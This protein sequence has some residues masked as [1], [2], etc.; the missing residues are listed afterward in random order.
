M[1]L[2]VSSSWF[3]AGHPKTEILNKNPPFLHLNLMLDWIGIE[4]L[5]KKQ[6]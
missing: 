2:I 1:L 5:G 3:I 4:I 6:V